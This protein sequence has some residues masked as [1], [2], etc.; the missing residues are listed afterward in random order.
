M[1]ESLSCLY[2]SDMSDEESIPSFLEDVR[3]KFVADKV[4]KLLQLQSQ[5]W[6]KSAASEDFQKLLKVFFEE[7]TVL[8]FS[9]SKKHRLIA[10]HEVSLLEKGY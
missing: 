8:F 5:T 10:T 4:C 1:T 9:S 7:E 6:E 3:V 2:I